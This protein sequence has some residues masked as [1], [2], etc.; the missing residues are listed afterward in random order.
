LPIR[1]G[2][3]NESANGQTATHAESG[4]N[5]ANR[6]NIYAAKDPA[7]IDDRAFIR[8]FRVRTP[9]A[10]TEGFCFANSRPLLA[11]PG[12]VIGWAPES[13][14]EA[15]DYMFRNSA[16][17]ASGYEVLRW[18]QQSRCG[19]S[20]CW[21]SPRPWPAG[22]A[23]GVRAQACLSAAAL[24]MT[25]GALTLATGARTGS[26]GSRSALLAGSAILLLVASFQ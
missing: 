5:D 15:D 17:D 16:R 7:I 24:L 3:A 25:L 1:R 13:L 12:S 19:A 20:P 10:S 11:S 2:I 22:E 23:A 18:P 21:S 14:R 8:S 4:R 26:P 6:A 9:D